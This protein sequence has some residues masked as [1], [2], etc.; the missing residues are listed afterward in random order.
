[1]WAQAQTSA[2]TVQSRANIDSVICPPSVIHVSIIVVDKF[3]IQLSNQST[4]WIEFYL[5]LR[6]I[7]IVGL[8]AH[9]GECS[10]T[11]IAD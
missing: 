4:K 7:E 6:P 1:M 9:C 10:I 8:M 11:F 3:S 5:M 2:K